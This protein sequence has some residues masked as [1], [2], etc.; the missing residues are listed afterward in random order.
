MGHSCIEQLHNK[1]VETNNSTSLLTLQYALGDHVT[2]KAT[3][4]RLQIRV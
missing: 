1:D 2:I 3:L 4:T